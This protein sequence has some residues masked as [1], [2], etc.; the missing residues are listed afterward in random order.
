LLRFNPTQGFYAISVVAHCILYQFTM[1]FVKKN[2]GKQLPERPL[3]LN[4]AFCGQTLILL[5]QFTKSPLFPLCLPR[6]RWRS[7]PKGEIVI[8]LFGKEGRGE[9]F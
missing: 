3:S 7:G 5:R 6:K 8:P 1:L 9:I 2:I 4:P